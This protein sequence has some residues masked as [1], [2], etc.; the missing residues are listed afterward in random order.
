MHK[1]SF[2]KD[3]KIENITFILFSPSCYIIMFTRNSNVD[4]KNYLLY[5]KTNFQAKLYS[6]HKK[7]LKHEGLFHPFKEIFHQQTQCLVYNLLGTH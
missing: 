1:F 7:L 6:K 3:D 4:Y 2:V 5:C